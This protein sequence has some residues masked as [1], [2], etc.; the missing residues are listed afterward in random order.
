MPQPSIQEAESSLLGTLKLEAIRVRARSAFVALSGLDD[1]FRTTREL[2]ESVRH[3]ILI[4][5]NAVP[6]VTVSHS[7]QRGETLLLNRFAIDFYKHGQHG[8]LIRYNGLKA[9]EA[10]HAVEGMHRVL[11]GFEY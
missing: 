9:G 4:D 10:Y 2:V 6:T 8:A 5:D 1:T 7:A 11:I 3:G